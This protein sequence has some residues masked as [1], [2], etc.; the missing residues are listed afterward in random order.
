MQFSQ[1]LLNWYEENKRSLPWRGEL[2]PYKIW[3]S[4]IILQQTRVNQGW[5]YYLRFIETFPDVKSLADASE[6]QVLKVWQG[7]GYY[8]RARNMHVAAQSIIRNHHAIF[9]KDYHDII[10]LK[11]IGDYTAA[12]VSSIAFNLPYPAVD[13]NVFRVICRIFGFFDDIALPATRKK[14]TETCLSLMDRHQSGIFNQA[15]MDFG[16]LHCT[17][18]NPQCG[19]CPFQLNCYAFNHEAV[20]RLPVKIKKGKIK[21]R[22]FHYFVWIQQGSTIIEKRTGNDIW[23]NL[24]QFPLMETE[25]SKEKEIQQYFMENKIDIAIEP[26]C[27]IKHQLTHQTIFAYFYKFETDC[28]PLLKKDQIVVSL[29]KIEQYPFPKIISIFLENLLEK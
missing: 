8:S 24:Y 25:T 11:G 21:E 2:D 22:Y 20:D 18:Q 7:L 10:S 15:M 5:E 14:V 28:L 16:A 27:Q 12:A 3:V 13:G 29:D 26:V 19:S 4:E 6:E 17:P 1:T 9:P 23:K